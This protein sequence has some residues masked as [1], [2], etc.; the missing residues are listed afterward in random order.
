MLQ[1][2]KARH[3]FFS[4]EWDQNNLH[5]LRILALTNSWLFASRKELVNSTATGHRA[6]IIKSDKI[7]KLRDWLSYSL[8]E[9]PL[10]AR[11]NSS[12]YRCETPPDSLT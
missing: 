6:L 12:Q 8:G 10:K 5:A 7:D 3:T 4:T 2:D 11:E 9:A 1:V